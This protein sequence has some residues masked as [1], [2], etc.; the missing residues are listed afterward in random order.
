MICCILPPVICT[1]RSPEPIVSR[2]GKDIWHTSRSVPI[3]YEKRGWCSV[4]ICNISSEIS[5][6][7]RRWW[8]T[9]C[10]Y[11]CWGMTYTGSCWW[12][13]NSAANSGTCMC[14]RVIRLKVRIVSIDQPHVRPIVRG[15][16]GCPTEFGAKVIV[17]LV[18]GY[19]FLMKADWNNYSESRSLKQVV[20][21]YKETFGF[22]PKTI[23]ADR[24]YPGRENRLWCTS[25]GIRLSGP[26]W[27]GSRQRRSRLKANRSTR[28]A[29]TAS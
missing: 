14:G 28:M 9:A 10:P 25:L 21:E 23:L 19:A 17:G 1:P 2:L 26:G 7:S 20:E 6:T 22:Y 15:K 11:R 12:S 16:A 18:S 4:G 3:L 29:A 8:P 27:D 13:R 24:A 5:A